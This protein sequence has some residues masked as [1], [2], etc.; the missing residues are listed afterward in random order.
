MILL[1]ETAYGNAIIC[2]DK[3]R[4]VVDRYT[5]AH[6]GIAIPV[7]ISLGVAQHQHGA[8]VPEQLIKIVD[9]YLREAKAKGRNRVFGLVD[10]A[11][12]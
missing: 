11:K 5:F 1:P 3:L 2:A 6:E 4:L 8:V 9:L 7:T 12:P 10:A